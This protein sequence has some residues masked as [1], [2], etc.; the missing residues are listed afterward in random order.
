MAICG[1]HVTNVN[2]S[3]FFNYQDATTDQT[4]NCIQS[5][6]LR[7]TG[8]ERNRGSG[9]LAGERPRLE[10]QTVP[11]HQISRRIADGVQLGCR[12]D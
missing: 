5:E 10:A 11:G 12:S 6:T 8:L 4:V 3:Y 1:G 9:T 2:S 7:L